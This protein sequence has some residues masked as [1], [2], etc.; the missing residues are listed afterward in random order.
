M[1]ELSP[2]QS[3]EAYEVTRFIPVF[4]SQDLP[5]FSSAFLCGQIDAAGLGLI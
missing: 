1:A 5:V 2:N 4:L 3:R